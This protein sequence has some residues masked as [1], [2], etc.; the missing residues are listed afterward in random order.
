MKNAALKVESITGMILA[1]DPRISEITSDTDL[2]GKICVIGQN[3][4]G[5]RFQKPQFQMFRAQSG[6]GCNPHASGTKVF[7]VEMADGEECYRR[8]YD[9]IGTI[10]ESDAAAILAVKAQPD[11]IDLSKRT[12]M[13]VNGKSMSYHK[14]DSL[15]KALKDAKAKFPQKGI[16]VYRVHPEAYV[17]D[18]CMISAPAG[19]T[20]EEIK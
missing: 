18:F 19:T 11:A 1:T 6:F 12:Y 2:T 17:N 5:E 14:D 15:A 13:V 3:H 9:F 7:G 8:R 20:I 10:S 16:A 4:L